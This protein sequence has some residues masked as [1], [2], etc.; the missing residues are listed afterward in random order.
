VSRKPTDNRLLALQILAGMRRKYPS[1]TQRLLED[2]DLA[3]GDLE[4]VLEELFQEA[5]DT[6]KLKEC[7]GCDHYHRPEFRGDCR[8][9]DERFPNW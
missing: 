6:G 8:N 2:L 3:E 4:E 9:D 7:G 1:A 5:I